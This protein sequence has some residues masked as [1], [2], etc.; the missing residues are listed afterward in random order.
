MNTSALTRIEKQMFW[1]RFV[2][3][4]LMTVTFYVTGAFS[5][6]AF[7]PMA[8]SILLFGTLVGSS[9]GLL[10]FAIVAAFAFFAKSSLVYSL[11]FVLV[12]VLAQLAAYLIRL[13]LTPRD[14]FLRLVYGFVIVAVIA[15]AII[16]TTFGGGYAEL[17]E[18]FISGYMDVFQFQS[19]EQ[20]SQF[21]EQIFEVTL[22]GVKQK[23][24][25]PVFAVLFGVFQLWLGVVFMLR[26]SPQW[27]QQIGYRSSIKELIQY[28][29]PEWLIFPVL[30]LISLLLVCYYQKWEMVN[31]AVISLLFFFSFFYFLQGFGVYADFL[32]YLRLKGFMRML[33][34]FVAV[35]FM[36]RMLAV[37]GFFD[38]WIN[39]RKFFKKQIES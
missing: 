13:Q 16:Y 15:G 1:A 24:L 19:A 25:L 14:L 21:R 8:V 10:S 9:V 5:V 12:I 17:I 34:V 28:K 3:M 31:V 22:L 11:G 37:I 29:N 33:F 39:F 6:L 2:L 23:Y 20:A 26:F 7:A 36:S 18:A 4:T 32:R 30:V 38:L 35:V 27:R